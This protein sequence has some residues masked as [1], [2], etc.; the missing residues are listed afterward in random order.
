MAIDL[1]TRLAALREKHNTSIQSELKS[2]PTSFETF[3]RLYNKA[4]YECYIDYMK[5]AKK[6]FDYLSPIVLPLIV[7][8]KKPLH[9]PAMFHAY[10]VQHLVCDVLI[11]FSDYPDTGTYFL[12]HKIIEKEIIRLTAKHILEVTSNEH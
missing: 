5:G 1:K 10:E 9:Y 6:L 11:K 2:T 12:H 3:L 4:G 7:E 8:D